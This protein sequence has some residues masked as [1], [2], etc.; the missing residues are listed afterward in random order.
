MSD[1]KLL[2]GGY[3]GITHNA[4]YGR[5][6]LNDEQYIGQYY[7]DTWQFRSAQAAHVYIKHI[8]KNRHVG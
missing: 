8:G 3:T 2:D 6:A 5:G 4:S 7:K 1:Y